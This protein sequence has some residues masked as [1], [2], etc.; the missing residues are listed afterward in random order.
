MPRQWFSV[1]WR[2]DVIW[3]AMYLVVLLGFL[4]GSVFLALAVRRVAVSEPDARPLGRWVCVALW[5][6]A[7]LT[8]LLLLPEFGV[9]IAIPGMAWLYP[10]IQPAGRALIGVWLWREAVWEERTAS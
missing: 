7:G 5:A 8:A 9:A 2:Y 4:A 3:D 6:A 1:P 10:L